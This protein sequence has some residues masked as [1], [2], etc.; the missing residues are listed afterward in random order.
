MTTPAERTRAVLGM[1]QAAHALSQHAHGDSASALVPRELLQ[2]LQGWLRH[3][4]SPVELNITARECPGLWA[5]PG[6]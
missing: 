1:A 5:P 4:P 6:G 2:A 3:Y